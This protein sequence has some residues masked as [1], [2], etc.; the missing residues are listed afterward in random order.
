MTELQFHSLAEFWAMGGHG[1]YVWSCFVLALVLV[2]GNW[3]ALRRA[4]RVFLRDAAARL[5][6]TAARKSQLSPP[7]TTSGTH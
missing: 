6:R 2:L 3:L 4:R 1:P 5:A 7:S